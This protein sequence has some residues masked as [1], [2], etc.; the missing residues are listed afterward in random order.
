MQPSFISIIIPVFNEEKN[1]LVL[2][3]KLLSI[4]YAHKDL[5]IYEIIFINDGSH[6][7]SWHVIEQICTKNSCVKGISFSRNFGYQAALTA[8]YDH[9]QGDAIIS[10]DS[11]LQHP[12]EVIPALIDAWKQGARI[13]YARRRARKDSLLKKITAHC[14]HVILNRISS[15]AIPTGISDFRLIDKSVQKAIACYRNESI[16]W[17]GIIAWSG[18]KAAYVDFFQPQRLYGKSGYTWG[19]LFNM[20]FDSITEFSLVPLRIAAFFGIF[21]SCTGFLMVCYFCIK[22]FSDPYVQY[23]LF[24]LLVMIIY[25]FTGIQFLL[26][27]ILGEYIGRIAQSNTNRPLY[28]V[29]SIAGTYN[30]YEHSTTHAMPMATTAGSVSRITQN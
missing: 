2:Y 21:I 18:F 22:M 8:G 25:C 6:D 15:L 20:A 9:A 5:Y 28:I 12:P 3:E 19:K 1:L 10:M 27:W 29:D 7:A 11:D 24:K 23:P 17:R 30:R 26:L 14:F 13:V 16:F 4:L